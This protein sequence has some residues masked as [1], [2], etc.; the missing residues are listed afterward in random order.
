MKTNHLTP[1]HGVLSLSLAALSTVTAQSGSRV[2]REELIA[3]RD[4][5]M[6]RSAH[7][8]PE[9]GG[10]VAKHPSQASI[11]DRSIL[12]VSDRNWTFVPEGALLN[13]PDHLQKRVRVPKGD[14]KEIPPGKYIPF[15]SFVQKNRG[16]ISAYNVT[17]SQARDPEGIS[18]EVRKA[19]T[20]SGR[21]VVSVC[22]GGP[23]TTR[24]P[25]PEKATA[26]N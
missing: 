18:P 25:K 24:K 5:A 26:Q 22:K 15:T 6:E 3:R 21:V 11:L 7:L 17:L 20:E 12:L 4:A 9:E 23:I 19:L 16:W 2:S 13:I 1:F 8:K 10:E 14:G